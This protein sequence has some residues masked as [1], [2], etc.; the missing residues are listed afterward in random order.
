MSEKRRWDRL[1][2]GEMSEST[3][4]SSYGPLARL[5]VST[6]TYA[7]GDKIE[8]VSRPC[9][10][11]VLS[12]VMDMISGGK[13]TRLGAEDVFFF[14]GGEYALLIASMAPVMTVWVW[15]LPATSA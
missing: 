10:V 9:A 6:Y 12:G 7:A 4:R 3:I 1:V 8:G 14:D 13:S 5:R 11:Y 15:E 2:G